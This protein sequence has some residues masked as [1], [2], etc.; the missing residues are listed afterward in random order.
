[1][2]DK[3]DIILWADDGDITVGRQ[4]S[5]FIWGAWDVDAPEGSIDEADQLLQDFKG[6]GYLYR[7]DDY[8]DWDRFDLLGKRAD[9]SQKVGVNDDGKPDFSFGESDT[10]QVLDDT[11]KEV[12]GEYFFQQSIPTSGLGKH[13]KPGRDFSVGDTVSVSRWGKLLTTPVSKITA[14]DTGDGE[15]W[16][17]DVGDSPIRDISTLSAANSE[18]S[19]K[20]KEENNKLMELVAQQKVSIEQLEKFFGLGVGRKQGVKYYEIVDGKKVYHDF[21]EYNYE[22]FNKS[23]HKVSGDLV[24]KIEESD[25]LSKAQ[26]A[27]LKARNINKDELV[28]AASYPIVPPAMTLMEPKSTFENQY[29]K[30]VRENNIISIVRMTKPFTLK[31][32]AFG[33]TSD[34]PDIYGK[35]IWEESTIDFAKTELDPNK[36]WNITC[37]LFPMTVKTTANDVSNELKPKFVGKNIA[38]QRIK[39]TS[40]RTNIHETQ[41]FYVSVAFKKP[42]EGRKLIIKMVNEAN[43]KEENINLSPGDTWEDRVPSYPNVLF[44]GILGLLATRGVNGKTGKYLRYE[45]YL[46]APN[47]GKDHTLA[48]VYIGGEDFKNINENVPQ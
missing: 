7:P 1:M 31:V 5:S 24:Q 43:G 45:I 41:G 25:A 3:T 14:V 18:I 26:E 28:N 37:S 2:A 29:I 15:R 47:D 21:Q 8:Q 40:G 35:E 42:G 30:I 23:F 36:D 19:K 32:S 9:V 11:Q 39:L 20:I 44:A 12:A 13:I 10:E 46:E 17:I 6:W 48:G 33:D 38:G 27:F 4:S 16:S 22:N 34:S